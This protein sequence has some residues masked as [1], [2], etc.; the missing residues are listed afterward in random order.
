MTAMFRSDADRALAI[1]LRR[2]L[3]RLQNG[4]GEDPCLG[5]DIREAFA[6]PHTL[7]DPVGCLDC[8]AYLA[9]HLKV[10]IVVASAWAGK[11]LLERMRD[12]WQPAGREISHVDLARAI[13]AILLKGKIAQLEGTPA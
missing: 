3:M 12:G 9:R 2:L 4:D 6:L 8:A 13:T 11:N 7:G 1:D 5:A 10:D